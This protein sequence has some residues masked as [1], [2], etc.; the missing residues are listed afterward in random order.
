ML[1][2]ALGDLDNGS[3][4]GSEA[5][6]PDTALVQEMAPPAPD[7]P[8]PSSRAR[9][10][11]QLDTSYLEDG[12]DVKVRVQGKENTTLLIEYPLVNRVTAYQ[13]SKSGTLWSDLKRFG[14]RKLIIGDGFESQWSWTIE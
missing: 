10:A 9:F 5:M 7:I 14:F 12:M 8:T 2:Q 3:A 13:F 6:L 1:V 11:A 4:Q